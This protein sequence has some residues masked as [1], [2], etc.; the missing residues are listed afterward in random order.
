MLRIIIALLLLIVPW[1]V[2]LLAARTTGAT[3]GFALVLTL[4]V[5][6]FGFTLLLGGRRGKND[7][8]APK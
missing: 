4:A 2:F 7:G 6:A 8:A 5:S 3:N 1:V